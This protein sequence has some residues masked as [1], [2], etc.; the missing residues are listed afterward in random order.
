MDS[1]E[2][3][4]YSFALATSVVG[5]L[6]MAV[7]LLVSFK[8]AGNFSSGIIYS[9]TLEGGKQ[10]GGVG[11]LAQTDKKTAIAPPKNLAVESE[12]LE[13][14]QKTEP[15]QESEVKAEDAEVSLAEKRKEE[16]RKRKEQ[17]R[18]TLEKKKADDL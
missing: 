9:V 10:I 2:R 7:L 3:A 15:S 18:A 4:Y 1:T 14:N 5:H 16:E 8:S 11:Q 17:E 6:F 13:R 12:E